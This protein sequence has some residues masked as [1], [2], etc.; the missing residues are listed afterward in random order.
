MKMLAWPLRIGGKVTTA[1]LTSL[2]VLFACAQASAQCD[3]TGHALQVL[4][5]G[6][7]IAD[8]GR[9]ST[10][11]ILW[12][13]GKSKILVDVGG[14][15]FLRF[16]EAKADFREL[17]HIAIS[18]FHTDHSADLVT[19]LKTGYFSN[20]SRPLG[21]SGPGEGGLFPGLEEYLE[22][23]IGK[24]GAYAYLAGYLDGSGGL[25][26]LQPVTIDPANRE[27]VPVYGDQQSSIQIEAIGVPHGIVPTLAYRV[28]IEDNVIVFA[29][30]QNGN[31]E[32]FIDFAQ[33]ADILVMHMVVPENISG[34]GR[35]L[36]APPSRIGQ[37]AEAAN[38]RTLVL[39]HFM[40]RSIENFDA[41]I[42]SI[43][44]NYAGEIVVS[45]DLHCISLDN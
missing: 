7:P 34:A 43:R 23:T 8:D 35:S 31:D 26:H 11:Y 39:S 41:N 20:R 40:A 28:R 32:T 18:H 37:I 45:S 38:A 16:G 17:D 21:I 36:H 1:I 13:D 3:V 42:Q 19:L 44:N 33:N 2:L 30:D 27:N 22:R 14:G 12:V 6:G 25:A 4:G 29:S 10:A 24:K 5:S 15:A 9:A